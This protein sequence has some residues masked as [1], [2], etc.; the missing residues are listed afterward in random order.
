M[1]IQSARILI[2][3]GSLGI[4]KATAAKLVAAGAKVAITGR[5][6]DR[7]RLAAQETGAHA[8]VSDVTIADDR[9]RMFD[10]TVKQFGGLDVLVNNAGIGEFPSLREVSLEAFQRVFGTNVFAAALV[11]QGAVEIFK[12]EGKGNIINVASTAALNGFESG[13]IYAASKFALRGMTQCWQRELRKHNIR[14]IGI[15]PSEVTTAFGNTA[16][17]ERPEVANK[18]RSEEIAHTIQAVL[19]MDDRGFIPE[20]TVWAT[21]PWG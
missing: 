16:G 6:E 8:V 3:G 13:T 20:V 10:E 12:R 2:T 14:V 11:A 7:L 18:L 5:H 15:N 19:E 1:Q 4:G 21:N 9:K 17:Q